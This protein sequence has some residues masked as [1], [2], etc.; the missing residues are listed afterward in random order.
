MFS[1]KRLL[2]VCRRSPIRMPGCLATFTRLPTQR[3][4]ALLLL[5]AGSRREWSVFERLLTTYSGLGFEST[6]DISR[7][8]SPNSY[9]KIWTR[10]SPQ[11]A[12]SRAKKCAQL[13]AKPANSSRIWSADSADQVRLASRYCGNACT[14]LR[15]TQTRLRS[16]SDTEQLGLNQGFTS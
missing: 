3:M 8:F 7:N 1:A 5:V 14:G 12:T 6:Q 13:P 4:M 11:Q 15:Y 10:L 9:R 16:S 2:D